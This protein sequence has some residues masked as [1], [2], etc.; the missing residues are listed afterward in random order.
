MT[1][2]AQINEFNRRKWVGE[3]LKKLPAGWRLL[4]AGAGEQQYRGFCDHLQYVSQDFA[5]YNPKEINSGLQ[6]NDWNYGKLDIVSDITAIPEKNASFDAILCTE[7]L[8]HVP[9]PLAALQE[10]SRLIRTGGRI[11]LTAPFCSMTHFAPYH[12][13]TG[14][15]RYFYEYHLPALGFKIDQ[16]EPNGNYFDSLYQEL[17]RLEHVA[18]EYKAGSLSRIDYFALRILKKCVER[19]GRNGRQSSELMCFGYHVIATRT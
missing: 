12:Y 15:S 7:V 14:F 6:M 5:Q 18:A 3:Q 13:A 9:N 4:D 1:S 2:P 16:I 8:E 11:I 17:G 19:L 10:L